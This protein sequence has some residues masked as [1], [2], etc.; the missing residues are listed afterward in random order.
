VTRYYAIALWYRDGT[1]TLLVRRRS[2]DREVWGD[3]PLPAPRW[4]DIPALAQRRLEPSAYRIVGE[5]SEV[6][7]TW[8]ADAEVPPPG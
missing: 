3:S 5:W 8:Q 4:A 6:G 2:D 1:Y 7:D